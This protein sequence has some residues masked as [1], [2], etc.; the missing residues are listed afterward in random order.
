MGRSQE[1]FGKKEREKKRQKKREQKKLLKE[2]RKANSNKGA[3]MDSMIAYVDAYGNPTDT[4]PDPT[5]EKEEISAESIE[6]GVPK[7]EKE[8]KP[9]EKTG[10]VAFFDTSKGYGF[11]NEEISGE[12]FF[13]HVTGLIDS[14]QENDQV[15]FEL[16]KG[17]KGLNA[18]KVEKI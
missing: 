12:R 5:V 3:D 10:K 15:R 11:I 18:V 17:P 13:V 9:F 7:R 1:S 4:P 14:I 16:E 2:E 6:I 8:A